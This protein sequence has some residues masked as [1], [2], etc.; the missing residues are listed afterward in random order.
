[1]RCKNLAQ[2]L[3]TKSE[4]AVDILC[5][6][7]KVRENCESSL[8]FQ[9]HSRGLAGLF[10]ARITIKALAAEFAII[11]QGIF[12]CGI[13]GAVAE[14]NIAPILLTGLQRL[15][16]RGYDSAGIGLVHDGVL[17]T[18]RAVG[19]VSALKQKIKEQNLRGT[20]GIAHTRWATHGVPSE[21]N[22]HPHSSHELISLVHN[23]IIENYI[24][25]K[26]ELIAAGYKFLSDTDSEAIVHLIHFYYQQLRDFGSSVKQAIGRLRG[27][28]ALVIIHRDYPD[29]LFACSNGAPLVLGIGIGEH[30]V[31]SDSFALLPVT[32]QFIY[33]ENG[34]LLHLKRESF[35]IYNQNGEIVERQ[36]QEVLQEGGIEGAK[37]AYSHFMQKE[38]YEQPA[39]I[40]ATLEGRIHNNKL[41]TET[42]SPQLLQ[43]LS[44]TQNIEIIACGTSYHAGL[45][46]RYRFEEL[47]FPCR[48][49]H[50]SEYIYRKNAV[51]SNTLFVSISQSGETADTLSA[52]EKAK[53]LPYLD[54]LSICDII[55]VLGR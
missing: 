36:A 35:T 48:V 38:I 29:E 3:G 50:A 33:L 46:A 32:R 30:F 52:L 43:A 5:W 27:A 6:R 15:E 45:V 55:Y 10:C 1:M 28:Y 25:I 13:V 24:E 39:V 40:A 23:G 7:G 54:Y 44:R 2:A 41:Q 20:M 14:R 47:G 9:A 8:E 34:D 12:M 42:I 11:K 19:K 21:K 37:G 4:F 17:Q 51:A 31:A 53:S 22:A 18:C 49:E 26:N 16:Y